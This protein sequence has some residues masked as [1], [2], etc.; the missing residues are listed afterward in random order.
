MNNA[1]TSPRVRVAVVDD[2]QMVVDGLI[3]HLRASPDLHVVISATSWGELTAHPEYPADVTVLDL[4][5]GDHIRIETKVRAIIAAGGGVVLISRHTSAIAIKRALDAG[6]LG[7]VPK[8]ASAEE[9][10]TAVHTVARGEQ[11]VSDL[12]VMPATTEA[13]EL[14]V[15]T[16]EQRALVLY[17]TGRSIRDVAAELGTTEETAKSYIKR[18]RSKYRKA[19]IELGT[20]VALRRHAA[21]EGWIESDYL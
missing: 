19:G 9:L 7:Y 21:L 5:L 14:S 15:G 6:A 17:A 10:V 1:H 13:T 3:T 11:Y 18:A 16:R 2:Y 20:I 8:T 4:N 12:Y